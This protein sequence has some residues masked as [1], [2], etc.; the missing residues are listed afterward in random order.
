MT[1]ITQ[2]SPLEKQGHPVTLVTRRRN[3]YICKQTAVAF[4]EKR[5]PASDM[6]TS[7][8]KLHQGHSDDCSQHLSH[9]SLSEILIHT[10]PR[11]H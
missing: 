7:L 6:L 8:A 3:Y 5:H 10:F 1:L 9:H 11:K 2:I 4:S